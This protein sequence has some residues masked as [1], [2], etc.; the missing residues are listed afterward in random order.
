MHKGDVIAEID[1]A[2][3]AA[4]VKQAEADLAIARGAGRRGRRAGL[5]HRGGLQG[6]A[7]VGEG[8]ARRLDRVGRLGR[9]AAAGGARVALARAGRCAKGRARSVA[10]QGAARRRTRCRRSASTTRRRRTTPPRAA[11]AG[12][13]AG[14]DG[15]ARRARR[16]EEHVGEARGRLSQSAPIAAQ[17]A[18]G[19][20]AGADL[21]HARVKSAEAQLELAR[22]QLGYTAIK[23]ARRRHG[24]EADGARGS[25]GRRRLS[26]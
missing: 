11:G 18:A 7:L 20:R 3:Y 25:A 8:G 12:Q 19:A 5:R 9:S 16:A 21:A 6:R 15:R 1:P 13:G 10:R 2:D 22:L 4:R 24:V 26:R 17:I 14:G 23:R